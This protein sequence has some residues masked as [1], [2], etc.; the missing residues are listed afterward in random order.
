MSNTPVPDA[1]IVDLRVLKDLFAQTCKKLDVGFPDGLWLKLV[2]A[3]QE[4]QRH[5]HQLEHIQELLELHHQHV[6]QT[7]FSPREQ[8]LIE[9]AIWGHDVIY[10]P[11]SKDNELKSA[12]W[13]KHHLPHDWLST[14]E[15][16]WLSTAI[17]AT[18][19]H[20][21]HMDPTIQWLLDLDLSIFASNPARFNRYHKQIKLEY[22]FVPAHIFEIKRHEIL[23]QF[24]K[25][26]PLFQTPI[27]QATLESQAKQN[28]S[29]WQK[30]CP[31]V[32]PAHLL[33]KPLKP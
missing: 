32:K 30:I 25:K 7:S 8:G 3:Y 22:A 11:Q 9:L 10:D 21:P 14:S 29:P 23:S 24:A 20:S 4:P 13:M 17:L 1:L 6:T 19:H 28:L 33:H 2:E 27:L 16:A 5:Y 26:D 12:E 15:Y 31:F 18:Q